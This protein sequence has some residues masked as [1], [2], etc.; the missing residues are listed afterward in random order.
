MFICIERMWHLMK[1]CFYPKQQTAAATQTSP[2][3]PKQEKNTHDDWTEIN[4]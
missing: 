2:L 3:K 1:M 4:F